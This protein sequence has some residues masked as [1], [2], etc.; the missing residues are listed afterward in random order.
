VENSRILELPLNGRNAA[1]LIVL[2]G[3]AVQT[4]TTSNRTFVGSPIVSV[5][6]GMQFGTAYTLD[7]ANL[8][9]PYNGNR[10]L[11]RFRMRCR[12]SR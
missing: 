6:G 8:R 9:D 5:S 3:G 11:C 4:G 12:N 2:A 1:D 10:Y 7:G